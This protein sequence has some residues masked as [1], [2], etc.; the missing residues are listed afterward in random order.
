LA[1]ISIVLPKKPYEAKNTS[2]GIIMFTRRIISTLTLS[3]VISLAL[4]GNVFA[5][6]SKG[7][8]ADDTTT[9]APVIVKDAKGRDGSAEVG[10]V[11]KDTQNLGPF[12]DK[13]LLDT[14]YT[15]NV[16]TED[17]IENI[18]ARNTGDIF[19]RLPNVFSAP[20]SEINFV[21][22]VNTRGF[23]SLN[24]NIYNGVQ[25]NNTGMGIFVEDLESVELMSGMSGFMYGANNLGGVAVYNLK[26]PTYTFMNKLRFGDYG[27]GQYFAHMDMGGPIADGK[28]AYRLNVL[29]QDGDTSIDRQKISKGLISGALDWN[30]SDD[31]KL[32]IHASYGKLDNDG[33]QQNYNNPGP[34]SS[35][36]PSAPDPSKLWNSDDTF[37]DFTSL[38][39]GAS[40]KHT[41]N[42][43]LKL[44]M[45]YAHREV[46][47]K[48]IMTVGTFV[49][50][51]SYTYDARALHW[52]DVSDGAYA[53]IDSEFKTFDIDHKLTF[54][55]NG[56][57]YKETIDRFRNEDG[58]IST[59]FNF[60]ST[61][62][63]NGTAGSGY[64]YTGN[65]HNNYAVNQSLSKFNPWSNN[66]YDHKTKAESST[67][68]N[69]MIG[70]EIKFNE[71]FQ[72]IAGLNYASQIFNN[73]NYWT[74]AKTSREKTEE[75][76]PTV[77]LIYKPIPAVTTYVSY[78]ESLEEGPTVPTT[79]T[80][81]SVPTGGWLNAGSRLDPYV[82]KQYEIGVKA[83]LSGI[84]LTTALFQ[85]DKDSAYGDFDTKIYRQDGIQRHRGIEFTV[86][87]RL[88][89]RLTLLGG[90][91]F[92]DAKIKNTTNHLYEGLRPL[93][94]PKVMAK[95]YAEYDLPFL[96]GLT[97]TGGIYHYG[98]TMANNSNLAKIPAFTTGDLGLRYAAQIA[99]LDTIWRL[100]VNNVTDKAYWV[101]DFNGNAIDLG[102]PRTV[103]LTAEFLF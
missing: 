67:N 34:A 101:G 44:R 94:V 93:Y 41:F 77:A 92:I 65:F 48:A 22:A 40:L 43:S 72:L 8:V 61:N 54:G 39:L 36:I 31:T 37:N 82:S 50:N 25:T 81:S 30:I 9:L 55:M 1:P 98:E 85:I 24:R 19:R 64:M 88:F 73:Y 20:G 35:F 5:Q 13:P 78:M 80:G 6:T 7:N 56:Y 47:R 76:T 57:T 102:T 3:I 38:N 32:Q 103:A 18:Q 96:D 60:T 49:D 27:G 29:A 26:Q 42:D 45:A 58:S 53:Y 97:L 21:S 66:L 71:Q 28:L 69:I 46:E 2:R 52:K 91:T 14:P 100:N 63:G 83:E 10:Y 12:T 90:A 79:T 62:M 33:R 74:G 17:F 51:Y 11:V 86:M 87:G 15:V 84:F 16:V 70:D 89:D 99:G 75:I 4:G 23:S 95:L 59:G 68:Y